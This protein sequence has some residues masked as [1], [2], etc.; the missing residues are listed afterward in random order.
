MDATWPSLDA[1]ANDIVTAKDLHWVDRNFSEVLDLI[2]KKDLEGYFEKSLY[3]IILTLAN[4][5]R[6]EKS[7]I[8]Q[9]KERYVIIRKLALLSE[10][11][12]ELDFAAKNQVFLFSVKSIAHTSIY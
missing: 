5:K 4:H 12:A 11:W 1:T 3:E 10:Y 8:A 6:N 9:E 7:D 2:E